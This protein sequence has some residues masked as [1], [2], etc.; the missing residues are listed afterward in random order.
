[1]GDFD[2]IEHYGEETEVNH[3]DQLPDNDVPTSLN[4][5][6]VGVGGGGGKLAKAFLDLGFNKTLLINT[7][8]KDQPEDIDPKHLVLIPDADG[9]GKDVD[10]GKVVFNNA[11]A[12]VEDALRTKLGHV[13]WLFVLAGGG[14]GT[15]SAATALSPV[16][17]RYL[18]SVQA[19]GKVVYIVSWPTAQEL[20][21]PTIGK[22]AM[23]LLNDV[24]KKPH[25]LLD[26]E[27]QVK[28][29]RGKVG[30]LNMYPVANSIFAKLLAQVLKLSSEQSSVQS[31]DSKDLEKC[32]AVDGRIFI[33]S[34][35]ITDPSKA[36]LGATIFQNC[37][38][39]S[40]CPI[41]QGKPATGTMLL[42]AT[43]AMASDPEVSKHLDA[44]ISYVGG[45]TKTLFS[46]VYVREELPGLVAILCMTGLK[47]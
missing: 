12:V 16:F 36:N 31:F 20:L 8:A 42:V 45:R 30:I 7:T 23:S 21:N 39:R 22:N 33:G 29:L 34:T 18:K 11:S 27:R 14:G 47:G 35:I 41:P 15:G 40:P 19:E 32:L 38:T 4:C 46:G 26:N 28:L 43:E 24:T 6:F 10:N 17:E 5:A 37:S 44:A 9:V 2:F 3:E 25:I 13:D 1:M